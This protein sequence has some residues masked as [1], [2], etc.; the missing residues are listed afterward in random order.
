MIIIII[1]IIITDNIIIMVIISP[2]IIS[3]LF[4]WY[5]DIYL[6]AATHFINLIFFILFCFCYIIL[7]Y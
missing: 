2:L 5:V 7:F 4:C 1:I 6:P 3:S